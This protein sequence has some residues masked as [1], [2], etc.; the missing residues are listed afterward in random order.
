MFTRAIALDER[1]PDAWL[2][3]GLGYAR[4]NNFLA[5]VPA[6]ARAAELSPGA[7]PYQRW[8]DWAR[9]T[10][11]SALEQRRPV[12]DDD[13]RPRAGD[14]R[15]RDR[16]QEPLAVGRDVVDVSP[17]HREAHLADRQGE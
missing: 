15:A 16:D 14:P 13:Q 10:S 17:A 9:T 11:R 8:L 12:R 6:L 5:A 7:E 1:S 4:R 3:L 2:H